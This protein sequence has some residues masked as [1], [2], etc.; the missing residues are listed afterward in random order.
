MSGGL[1]GLYVGGKGLF[2]SGFDNR[3][4]V[5]KSDGFA[6]GRSWLI[7]FVAGDVLV[8]VR[9]GCTVDWGVDRV[10]RTRFCCSSVAV[11]GSFPLVGLRAI[12]VEVEKRL[13]LMGS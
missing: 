4:V 8:V 12:F 13:V 10:S 2:S 5:N 3:G 11:V 9:G 7:L 1:K 6:G